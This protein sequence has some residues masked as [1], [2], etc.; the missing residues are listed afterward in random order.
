MGFGCFISE[1]SKQQPCGVKEITRFVYIGF[2]ALSSPSLATGVS[3]Y[4]QMQ[5]GTFH[6]G[7]LFPAF[8]ETERRVRVSLYI[9]SFLSFLSNFNHPG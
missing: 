1:E 7:D 5:V 6:R 2:L 4:L 9:S 8:R 3:F